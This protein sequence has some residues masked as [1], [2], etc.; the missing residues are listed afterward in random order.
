MLVIT[1]V[2]FSLIQAQRHSYRLA[3]LSLVPIQLQQDEPPVLLGPTCQIASI[4]A[5]HFFGRC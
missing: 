2:P 3:T 4:F 1:A 5:N